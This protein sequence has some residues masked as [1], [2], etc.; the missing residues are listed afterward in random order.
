M[1]RKIA[2]V[3][4]RGRLAGNSDW[5]RHYGGPLAVIRFAHDGKAQPIHPPTGGTRLG[6]P[7]NPQIRSGVAVLLGGATRIEALHVSRNA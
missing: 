5:R 6:F 1:N 3:S 2:R 4:A 7:D